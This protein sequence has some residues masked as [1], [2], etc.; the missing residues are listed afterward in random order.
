MDD[1]GVTLFYKT[2]YIL[3]SPLGT[4]SAIDTANGFLR[5]HSGLKK[6]RCRTGQKAKKAKYDHDY[7]DSAAV[8]L[9]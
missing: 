3:K 7:H 6:P 9:V 5:A 1:L 4:A 2:P 8:T